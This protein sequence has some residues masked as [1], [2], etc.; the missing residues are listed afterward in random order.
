MKLTLTCE[1]AVIKPATKATVEV[2]LDG[3]W[4]DG[5]R[6]RLPDIIDVDD[7]IKAYSPQNVLNALGNLL[8]ESFVQ[9]V[10]LAKAENKEE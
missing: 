6:D 9:E 10:V 4:V 3:V 1:A 8:G 2:I 5:L 7:I